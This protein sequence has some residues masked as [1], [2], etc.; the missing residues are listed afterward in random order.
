[1]YA[2]PPGRDVL[3]APTVDKLRAFE[4]AFW[5]LNR[6]HNLVARGEA[7]Q[8]WERHIKH[9][10]ALTM[11]PFP[12]GAHVVDW[13]TGG[14]LPAIPLAIA[15]PALRVTAVDSVQKKIWAVRRLGRELGLENLGTWC[16]RALVWP[17]SATHSVSRATAPLATLW[18]W[19][20]RIA[21]GGRTTPE[22]AWETGLVC[23]KGG[24]LSCEM[25]AL[26]SA[27][28][29]VGVEVLPL[30]FLGPWFREKAIIHVFQLP[31]CDGP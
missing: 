7:A 3:D 11:R 13:G 4:A 12:D 8:F 31:D 25:A 21:S 6:R 10:L 14:G 20:M 30:D 15:A 5:K 26:H 18:Q 1:M 17:G 2:Q 22:G 28:S 19:H 27:Y 29:D 24:D 23:L 9:S 16:G